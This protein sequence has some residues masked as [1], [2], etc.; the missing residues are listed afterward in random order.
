M[1]LMRQLKTIKAKRNYI[2][3]DYGDPCDNL[4]IVHSG[5]VEVNI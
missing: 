3:Y 1:G 4:Y 5:E 2:V